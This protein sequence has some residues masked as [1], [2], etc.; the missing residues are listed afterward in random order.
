MNAG[1]NQPEINLQELLVGVGGRQRFVYRYNTY[2]V[3]HPESVAEH[4]HHVALLT[5]AIGLWVEAV[6]GTG[7]DM[8]K[9]LMRAILHDIE[10]AVTGDFPRPFKYS[11]PRLHAMLEEAGDRAARSVAEAIFPRTG[12]DPDVASEQAMTVLR[13]WEMSKAN[14]VEGRTVRLADYLSVLSF[15]HFEARGRPRLLEDHR[16]GM[17]NYALSFYS[18]KDD[19]F[20]DL[21]DEGGIVRFRAEKL[22]PRPGYEVFDPLLRQAEALRGELWP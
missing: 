21:P 10:E 7:F 14:D 13:H 15:F 5:L 12:P 2:P 18:L 11:D 20:M 3:G 8:R 4:S 19:K 9:A 6:S 17:L 16:E 1:T 22:V